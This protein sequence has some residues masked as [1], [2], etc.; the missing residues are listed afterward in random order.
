MRYMSIDDAVN[1]L[2]AQIF[3][4][5]DAPT[6]RPTRTTA[7]NGPPVCRCPTISRILRRSPVSFA[8]PVS[9]DRPI[10]VVRENVIQPAS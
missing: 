6:L 7:P 2:L 3:E 4:F 10:A 5:L 8:M 9:A 1:H